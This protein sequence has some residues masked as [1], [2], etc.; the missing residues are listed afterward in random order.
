VYNIYIEF[1]HTNKRLILFLSWDA[2][3]MNLKLPGEGE[4]QEAPLGT[5]LAELRERFG[6]LKH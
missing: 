4:T 1:R 2:A 3:E 6:C 5:V